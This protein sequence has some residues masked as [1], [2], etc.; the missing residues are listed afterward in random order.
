MEKMNDFD[1]KL[2]KRRE[3]VIQTRH[4]KNP[5]MVEALEIVATEGKADKE[6]IAVKSIRNK[7]GTNDFTIEAF[8]YHTKEQKARVEPKIKVKK[9]PGAA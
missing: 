3:V 9:A 5:S 1:N 2:M 6:L 4:D 8:V 7:F